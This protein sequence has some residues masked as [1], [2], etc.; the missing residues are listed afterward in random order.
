MGKIIEKNSCSNIEKALV[1]PRVWQQLRRHYLLYLMCIPGILY[2][3]LFRYAPMWGILIAFQD[4]NIFR[5]F[6]ESEWVGFAHF[7]RFFNS[8]AFSTLMVNT[9]VISLLNIAFAFP[10]PIILALLLNEVR[11]A[12]FKRSIQ[13]LIYI[14]HFI[15]WVI[16]ASMTFMLL[17][18]G[19]PVDI[20]LSM[21]G[22][23]TVPFLTSVDTFRPM[24]VLQGIW[25]GAGFGTI[26]FLAALAGVDVEQYEAA[27]VD[28]ASRFKQCWHITLP[29][30]RSVVIL[31]LILQMGSILETGFD[32]LFLMGNA[33]NR[34][35]SDV[36]AVFVFRE[37][38]VGG[39]F[40]Y[41]SAIGLFQSVIGLIFVLGADRL[42]KRV[43]EFGIF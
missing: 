13:T 27:I 26:V 32:Q 7:M 9:L 34:S 11:L 6:W 4:Y 22:F 8:P 1:F 41:T 37:G 18:S 42:A 2:F 36:L 31:L 28:G 35:V 33:G 16:V 14:P 21:F 10:A 20:I 29:A 25:R 17:R 30:L 15:S 39:D 38:V 40:S 19:G 23:D 24:I 43:G 3:I 5:G 12:W